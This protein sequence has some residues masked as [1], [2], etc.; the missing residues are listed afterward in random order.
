MLRNCVELLTGVL[1]AVE[2]LF[3]LVYRI[4][5]GIISI[6]EMADKTYQESMQI[7]VEAMLAAVQEEF[8][9]TDEQVE[10]F[11]E[12]FTS[13]LPDSMLRLLQAA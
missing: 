2:D 7:I 4:T 11:Y 8:H 6:A 10:V 3:F 1:V 9:I 5:E 13:K 12:K